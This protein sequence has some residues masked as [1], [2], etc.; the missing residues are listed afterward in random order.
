[1]S[2]IELLKQDMRSNGIEPPANF[3]VDGKYHRFDVNNDKS[4]SNNGSYRLFNNNG[5]LAGS[6]CCWKRGIFMK[7]S[8]KSPQSMTTKEKAD[9]KEIMQQH[10]KKQELLSAKCREKAATL[11]DDASKD[12][13]DEHSYTVRKGIKPVNARTDKD[14]NLII[15][16]RDINGEFHGVQYIGPD[17]DKR[18]LFGTKKQ[19]N[20]ARLG[21]ITDEASVIIICE[22]WATG[23]SL[24]QATKLTIIVAFDC[25][26]LKPVAEVWRAELP[27]IVIIIA[28]D[29]DH[30][31]DG[32][33]GKTK[34]IEA[35]KAV[36]GVTAFPKFKDATG[37]TDFN[38]MH[39]EQGLDA[40]KELVIEA[41]TKDPDD[42]DDE[43][44]PEPILFGNLET[45]KI[46]YS[47]LPEP[48]AGYC[49]AVTKQTQTP[50]GLSI[51][52]GLSIVAT[53][54]QKRF[55][56]SPYEDGY[57]EP[58]NIMT[59]VALDPASRK[60]AVKNALLEPLTMWETEQ[61]EALKEQAAKVCHERDMLKKSIESIKTRESKA[62]TSEDDRRAALQEIQTLEE[63]M[64]DEIVMPHLWTDDVT[65]ER[66]QNL[67][68]E[69]GERIAILSD[70]GGIFEVIAGLYSGGKININVILQSHAGSPV[71]V[72]RQGRSVNMLKP[73]LTFGL[74]VQ[75]DIIIDLASGNKARFRG[76]GMLARLLYCI[77][78]STV[79]R[80]DVTKRRSV[81][82]SIKTEY[83]KMISRLL[84][85]KPKFDD[86]GNE[87]PRILTLE[88]EALKI[89]QKFSQGIESKQGQDGEFHSMQDW[90]G[91]LPGAALRIAGL[92]H[93]VEH[94]RKE[95]CINKT[96]MGRALELANLLIA[97]AKVAFG[98]MGS[99]PTVSDAKIVLQWIIRNNIDRI[100]RG[101]L[102]RALHGRFQRVDRLI[103]AL[104]VLQERHIISDEQKK[105]T[106][107]R[108]EI[109][110]EVNPLVLKG[111]KG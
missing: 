68:M 63:S 59:V 6:Y 36:K 81:P 66:L 90:T 26:N 50:P 77:P 33:P 34:A 111:G 39:I 4:G 12:G 18:T 43:T 105:Y 46:P 80:R 35:A 54:L 9:F 57:T 14:D 56:V 108:P 49:K 47:V 13:I 2:N 110:Y 93:I 79:G 73:A 87:Q 19:G 8:S 75:P 104:K 101:D 21:K 84:S 107:R 40:V 109:V 64:P 16:I 3:N 53:C 38:D 103:S 25:N 41:S 11:W 97:H 72:Q 71:R 106:G 1:M 74:T 22:G 31:T 94:G 88:P 82:E 37:R 32:N 5:L 89:W 10:D 45:P 17:G 65:T 58:V 15:P 70:E 62:D 60:T 23:C 20:F 29:D 30:A 92:C 95:P 27:E 52:T 99:D 51:M 86:L 24:R 85:I 83:H 69:N 96:T 100:R 102:H 91:K 28:G 98:L 76:N 48:L 78:K 61:A 7:W 55:E 42:I 44:W 67:M